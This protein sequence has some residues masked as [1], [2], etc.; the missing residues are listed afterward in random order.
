MAELL[1]RDEDPAR[2]GGNQELVPFRVVLKLQKV[3]FDRLQRLTGSHRSLRPAGAA[4]SIAA[5]SRG[6]VFLAM[7][8]VESTMRIGERLAST[9]KRF[10]CVCFSIRSGSTLLCHDLAQWGLGAPTEYFQFPVAPVPDGPLSDYLVKLVEQTPGECFAIKMAWEQVY[11]LTDRLRSEGDSSV[12]FDLGTVFP[13]VRYVHIVRMDKIAQ[14]VS[15]WRAA[16]SQTWHWPVGTDVDPGRPRYNFEE[17]KYFLLQIIAEDWLWRSYFS[18]LGVH[19]LTVN[20]ED[21]LVERTTYLDRINGLLGGIGSPTELKDQL[22]VMRDDW[23]ESVV[24]L[25]RA[26]LQ[27]PREPLWARPMD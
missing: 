26:D 15:A 22:Q 8:L 17:I 4:I 13:D 3:Q 11:Q 16:S 18:D 12:R 7:A 21:Y 9:G 2:A 5:A 27:A 20:Y 6:S 23:T 14:A 25:V 1:F 19:P 24:D 10:Y